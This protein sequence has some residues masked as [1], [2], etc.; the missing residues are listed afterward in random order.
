ML[1]ELRAFIFFKVLSVYIDVAEG[2]FILLGDDGKGRRLSG[3]VSAEEG[4][5]FALPYGKADVPKD[6][7]AALFVLEP[8]VFDFDGLFLRAGAFVN[9]P[10]GGA[11]PRRKGYPYILR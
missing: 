3:S 10:C 11:F 4:A 7:L 8:D 9:F 5:D 6:G 2:V 1:K